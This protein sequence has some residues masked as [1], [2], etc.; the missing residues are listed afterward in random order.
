MRATTEVTE[1]RIERSANNGDFRIES[2]CNEPMI[3]LMPSYQY[4]DFMSA[5]VSSSDT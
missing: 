1:S 2:L 4:V 3:F 5:L